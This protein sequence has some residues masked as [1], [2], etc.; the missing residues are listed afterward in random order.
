MLRLRRPPLTVLAY[1]AG[2]LALIVTLLPSEDDP[3]ALP[4]ALLLLALSLGLILG[5]WVAWLVLIALEI[6]NLIVMVAE[7]TSSWW[8]AV[9]LKALMVVLLGCATTRRHVRPPRVFRRLS[10]A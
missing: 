10:G 6:G 3:G 4:G 2:L 8:W 5:S 9:P 1:V 7:F